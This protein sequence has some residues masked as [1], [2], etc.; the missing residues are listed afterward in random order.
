MTSN[1]EGDFITL[2]KSILN[3]CNIIFDDFKTLDGLIIPREL[4]M[5][6][7]K[8]NDI[9]QEIEKMKKIFSSSNMTCLHKNAVEKQKFPTLNLVRQILKSLRY[10]MEPVRKSAGYNKE[11][12]KIFVRYFRIVKIKE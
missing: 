9:E 8:I 10:K 12:K 4:F 7:K 1:E 6:S 3:K 5:D 11:R 2:I